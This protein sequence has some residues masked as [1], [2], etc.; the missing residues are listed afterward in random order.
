M[1]IG[2]LMAA[3][4]ATAV[5]IPALG[6]EPVVLHHKPEAGESYTYNIKARFSLT[7]GDDAGEQVLEQQARLRFTVAG[8]DEA[9]TATVRAAFESLRASFKPAGKDEPATE[10]QWSKGE[11]AADAPA[12]LVSPMYTELAETFLQFRVRADGTA[13]GVEGFDGVLEAGKESKLASPH[14]ALGIFGPEAAR[15]H[16]GVIWGLD[17]ADGRQAGQSWVTSRT[18]PVTSEARARVDKRWTLRSV[19]GGVAVLTAPV[20]V[21]LEAPAR[22]SEAE[23]TMKIA[24][25]S[26]LAAAKW[27]AATRRLISCTTDQRLVWAFELELEEPIRSRRGTVSRVEI[28]R[29]EEEPDPGRE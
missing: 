15:A 13:E 25:Q 19:E 7:R 23:P 29:V 17:P 18:A 8:I 11:H 28:T 4:A 9:G 12:T 20:V 21:S 5:A 27:D 2:G 6:Q 3:A 24:E 10:F 14:Q 1:R 16:L 26:G 22:A